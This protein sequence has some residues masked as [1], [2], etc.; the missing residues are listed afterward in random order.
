MMQKH[1]KALSL[2]VLESEPS[3]TFDFDHILDDFAQ[4]RARRK[5]RCIMKDYFMINLGL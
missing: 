3:N 2:M 5:T 4:S 1:P